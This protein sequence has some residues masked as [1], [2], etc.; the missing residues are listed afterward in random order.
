MELNKKLFNEMVRKADRIFK[1]SV[2]LV[3]SKGVETR[4]EAYKGYFKKKYI[5][6]AGK[7]WLL[8][9][10]PKSRGRRVLGEVTGIKAISVDGETTLIAV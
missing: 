3:T 10:T 1:E 7:W 9:T 5:K 2:I 4:S 8:S 6:M